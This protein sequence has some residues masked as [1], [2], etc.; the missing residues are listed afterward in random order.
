M[1]RPAPGPVQL[2]LDEARRRASLPGKAVRGF[3]RS[4]GRPS[5]SLREVSHK[6]SG[7]VEGL[8]KAFSP[9]SETPLNLPI[10]PHRRFDWTRF[11][12]GVVR[13]IKTKLGGTVNDVV[14]A[15]V[16]GA[17]RSYLLDRGF[18]VDGIDFRVFIPVST[19]SE[20]QRGKLG[21]RV[22]MVVASLPVDEEDAVALQNSVWLQPFGSS[23]RG[24][25]RP[26]RPTRVESEI[27]LLR[28]PHVSVC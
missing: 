9:A 19:R 24:G 16:S 6:A 4:L 1:P 7:F 23:G 2:V 11:D 21:N 27:P 28:L 25:I 8:S 22:S 18:E 20:A 26:A 17:V 3:F 13:E 15:C 14:L 5:D 10:G 12:L